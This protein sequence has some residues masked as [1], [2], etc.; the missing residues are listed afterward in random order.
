MADTEG[1]NQLLS[2]HDVHEIEID[3][4]AAFTD[5]DTPDDYHRLNKPHIRD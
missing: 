4:P 1:V 2:R 3:D 5:I